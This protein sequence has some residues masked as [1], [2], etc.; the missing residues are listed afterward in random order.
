MITKEA[1]DVTII[2][3]SIL[4]LTGNL[5]QEESRA[6]T[7]EEQLGTDLQ[8]TAEQVGEALQMLN[9]N[10]DTK[11]DKLIAGTNITIKDNVISAVSGEGGGSTVSVQVDDANRIIT[12][13]LN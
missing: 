1:S 10:L 3:Q 5:S 11:Q 12:I 8:Q 9:T 7:A 4:T 2:N 6:K 13:N